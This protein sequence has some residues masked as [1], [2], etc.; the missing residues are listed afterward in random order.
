LTGYILDIRK[1]R[2]E[3]LIVSVLTINSL[4]VLYRFY[5]A[6]HSAILMGHKIDFEEDENGSFLPRMRDVMHINFNWIYNSDKLFAWQKFIKFLHYHLKDVSNI[7]S[8]Y[9]DLLESINQSIN[10][11]C[12]KRAIIEHFISMRKFEGL[13]SDEFVCANCHKQIEDILVISKELTPYHN[14]CSA[15]FV[16]FNASEVK[17][18]FE[19]GNSFSISDNDINKIYNF[20]F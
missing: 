12:H 14:D 7:P 8:F 6:R 5:G 10:H 9:F 19:V 16:S 11:Q 2:E 18:L 1:S 13:M 3:D 4:K 17:S 20:I 15:G